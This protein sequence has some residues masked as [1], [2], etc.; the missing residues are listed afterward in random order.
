MRELCE[1]TRLYMAILLIKQSMKNH[2]LGLKGEEL[3]ASMHEDMSLGASCSVSQGHLWLRELLAQVSSGLEPSQQHRV[4]GWPSPPSMSCNQC[5][6]PWEGKPH[7]LI[8]TCSHNHAF[9][10]LQNPAAG[11]CQLANTCG[12]LPSDVGKEAALLAPC[13]WRRFSLSLKLAAYNHSSRTQIPPCRVG[14][15]GQ[16]HDNTVFSLLTA[17]SFGTLSQMS[18][19][20]HRSANWTTKPRC[21]QRKLSE[22][23]RER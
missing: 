18:D 23:E 11:V 22:S 3:S 20:L 10:F 2:A 16:F 17:Q 21:F 6:A 8:T 7:P 9:L 19:D 14:Q 5:F 13:S 4:C 15:L 1:L 12:W